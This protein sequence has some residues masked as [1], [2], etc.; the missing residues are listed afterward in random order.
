MARELWGYMIGCA[1]YRSA[2]PVEHRC[3]V[4]TK[5]AELGKRAGGTGATWEEAFA[6]A[7]K[8]GLS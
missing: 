5:G 4:G 1:E 8:R 6:D 7:E 2:A 3:K